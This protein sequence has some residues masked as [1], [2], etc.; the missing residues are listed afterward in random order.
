VRRVLVVVSLIGTCLA[1]TTPAHAD[2][3]A[4]DE[5]SVEA[6][7][8]ADRVHVRVVRR[9][10]VDHVVEGGAGGRRRTGCTRTLVPYRY[11]DKN[12][13][14][15][16]TAGPRPDPGARPYYSYCDGIR[17]GIV[18][19][20]PSDVVDLDALAA[21]EAQRYLQ[22]V[23]VPGLVLRVNPAGE[24]LVGLASWFWIDGFDTPQTVSIAALGT[25]AEV[26][27]RAGSVRW[28]FGDGSPPLEADLGRAFPTESSV[29][30]VYEQHGSY[31]VRAEV[32][33]EAEYRVDGGDW[34]PLGHLSAT[35]S[36]EAALQQRQAVVVD[37]R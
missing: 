20:S 26:R 34:I 19:V 15:T 13:D 31:T 30:H 33:V 37:R 11:T 7:A 14:L 5:T 4:F 3:K 21:S 36:A 35:T 10:G 18:W 29:Q 12:S 27:M 9:G 24:G 25:A 2:G 8:G 6:E 16:V 28:D 32:D 22:D 23:L 1:M 17:T